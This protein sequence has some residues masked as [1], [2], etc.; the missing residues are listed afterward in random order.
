M[1]VGGAG[2]FQKH[3]ASELAAVWDVL[4]IQPKSQAA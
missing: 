3:S 1:V 2:S 4:K